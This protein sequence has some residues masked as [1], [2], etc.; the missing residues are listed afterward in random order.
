[1]THAFFGPIDLTR[2]MRLAAVHIEHHTR[3][4][5]AVR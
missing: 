3:Q 4:L 1:M 2:G 5:A